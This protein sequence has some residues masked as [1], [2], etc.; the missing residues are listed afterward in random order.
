MS[1]DLRREHQDRFDE[2]IVRKDVIA[3]AIKDGTEALELTKR[4]A[5]K[6]LTAEGLCHAPGFLGSLIGDISLR[7]ALEATDAAAKVVGTLND[8]LAQLGD[9]KNIYVSADAEKRLENVMFSNAD[10]DMTANMEAITNRLKDAVKD[11]EITLDKLRVLAVD[12][13]RIV[14]ELKEKLG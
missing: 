8:S 5:K 12:T 2:E 9:F 6:F 13:D 4:A 1:S 10:Q 7:N 14:S 3:K 11:I